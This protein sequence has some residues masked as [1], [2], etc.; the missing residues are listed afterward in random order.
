MRHAPATTRD[1]VG[2]FAAVTSVEAWRMGGGAG[3]DVKKDGK[4]VRDGF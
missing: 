2:P 3:W 4:D 1:K